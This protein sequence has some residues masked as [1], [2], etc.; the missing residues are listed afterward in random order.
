VCEREESAAGNLDR[1]RVE[2]MLIQRR[3]EVVA[4]QYLRD[5]RRA[6]FVDVRI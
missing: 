2:Q 5:L 3:M 6:A 4:E 1:A